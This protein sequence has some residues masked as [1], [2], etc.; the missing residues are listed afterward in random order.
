[1]LAAT[2]ASKLSV[3]FELIRSRI[4]KSLFINFKIDFGRRISI[5]WDW[6][7]FH[8]FYLNTSR[9]FF[10]PVI[11]LAHLNQESFSRAWMCRL[12]NNQEP[13][14]NDFKDRSNRAHSDTHFGCYIFGIAIYSDRSNEKWALFKRTTQTPYHICMSVVAFKRKWLWFI[15]LI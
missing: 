13:V 6:H 4:F 2:F 10:L 9:R 1:M 14:R 3:I 5:D 7:Q 8:L 15:I 11:R 12:H